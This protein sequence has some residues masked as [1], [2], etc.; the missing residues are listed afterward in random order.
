[1]PSILVPF[2]LLY[3]S[4]YAFCAGGVTGITFSYQAV[5]G[6]TPLNAGIQMLPYSLGSSLASM[7]A[8]WL[9]GYVQTKT[10]DTA[11]QK[12]TITFGLLVSTIGFGIFFYLNDV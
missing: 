4:R 11:A 6:S 9:I 10:G 2:T 3:T 8:A 1:M 7:P 12:W 5:N